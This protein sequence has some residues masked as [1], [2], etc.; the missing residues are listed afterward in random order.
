MMVDDRFNDIDFFAFQ[1]SDGAMPVPEMA[2]FFCSIFFCALPANLCD[3]HS[4]VSSPL[5]LEHCIVLSSQL[6]Q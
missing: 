4:T 6:N 1:A 2:A 5:H 3:D